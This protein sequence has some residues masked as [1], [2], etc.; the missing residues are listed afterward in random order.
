LGL[1]LLSACSL[2]GAIVVML[3]RIDVKRENSS[4]QVVMAQQSA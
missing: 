3:L 4:T 2:L 1:L